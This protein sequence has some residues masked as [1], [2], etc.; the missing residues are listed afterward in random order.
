MLQTFKKITLRPDIKGRSK[1]ISDKGEIKFK[2][3][4]QSVKEELRL[5][6]SRCYN[7]NQVGHIANECKRPRRE[8]GSCYGCG[9]CGHK[10]KDCQ[11]KAPV[12]K[13]KEISNIEVISKDHDFKRDITYEINY[14]NINHIL[15]LS[16][17]FD[18]G[19][20]V[21][22]I[23]EQFVKQYNTNDIYHLQNNFHGINRSKLIL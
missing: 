17:L 23:R 14:L 22:F 18:T 11:K 16:T 2:D 10:I 15:Q 19:S 13:K 5:E 6:D 7:C 12:A 20:P 4:K 9:E 21:S 1:I 8:K 3:F